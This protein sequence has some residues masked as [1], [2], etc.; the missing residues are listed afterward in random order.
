MIYALPLQESRNEDGSG[1]GSEDSGNTSENSNAASSSS[2]QPLKDGPDRG[3]DQP[4]SDA[5]DSNSAGPQSRNVGNPRDHSRSDVASLSLVSRGADAANPSNPLVD[6]NNQP[7]TSG[8]IPYRRPGSG[9]VNLEKPDAIA[10]Y[11]QQIRRPGLRVTID[12]VNEGYK[13]KNKNSF[14]DANIAIKD[15]NGTAFVRNGQVQTFEG[16]GFN[17]RTAV[18]SEDTD[19]KT[20][21]LVITAGEKEKNFTKNKD[22]LT[23]FVGTLNTD[24]FSS[25]ALLT[26]HSNRG[27][28]GSFRQTAA[29]DRETRISKQRSDSLTRGSFLKAP[30]LSIN[31]RYQSD[32]FS[33]RQHQVSDLALGRS[34]VAPASDS[35]DT[36]DD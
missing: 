12:T 4:P 36:P 33:N 30:A 15:R 6:A 32:S 17:M 29:G 8:M 23:Q 16:P 24:E 27:T 9:A 19:G 26:D 1:G 25:G 11:L 35:D 34:A 13:K 21:T 22:R 18:L 7:G 20:K 14:K 5:E 28:V 2:G 3:S 10:A 31:A